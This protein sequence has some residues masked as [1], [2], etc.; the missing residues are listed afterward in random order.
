MR[1]ILFALALFA[2]PALGQGTQSTRDVN[3]A[4]IATATATTATNTTKTTAGTSATS[5]LPVQGVTGGVALPVS[6]SVS[7]GGTLPA[8][9]ATPTV[10]IG[11]LPSVAVTGTFWQT[12]QPVSGAASSFADGWNSTEGTKADSAWTTGSGSIDAVLKAIDRD[13]NAPL[14]GAVTTAA[15][16]YTSGTTNSVSLTIGGAMRDD[17]SSYNSTAL[18]GT[19]TAYGTAPTGNVFGVNAAVTNTV[20]ISAASLPLPSGAA[21]SAN[22]PT[23]AAQAGSITSA[24]GTLAMTSTTTATPT[25]T[26]ATMNP[27]ST[28]TQGGL[29]ID[30]SSIAGQAQNSTHGNGSTTNSLATYQVTAT[31]ST[32]QNATAFAGAG[33][34]IGT[35]VTG[36]T[37]SG[38]VI[39]GSI[40]V[41]ALTLGTASGVI[42]CAQELPDAVNDTDI[43]CSDPATATGYIRVPA[44]S[45]AGRRRWR[46]FSVGGT[47]TTV[48]A[49]ITVSELPSGGNYPLQHQ[50]RDAYAATN[51]FATRI[52]GVAQTASSLVLTTANSTSTVFYVEG[53]KA[54]TAFV[55]V[56]GGTPSTNPVLTLQISLDCVN[57][58]AS[59]VTLTPTAAGTFF[60]SLA[61]TPARCARFIVSTAS[62]GGS[63]YTLGNLGINAVN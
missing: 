23:N 7:I 6:G 41:T 56:T 61:N 34:V 59:G 51:P 22:Q 9:A 32:D 25:Y 29:R 13:I 8:F 24:T 14:P 12:T 28:T 11:T 19:V 5:A 27:L 58:G 35:M 15:P 37:G 26:T 38:A 57:Y 55:T 50:F 40:N 1:R 39:A 43:W 47:S 62:S 48:T 44:L 52:N 4:A 42:F 17:I 46:A 20:A 10:N 18:T 21:T 60:G 31:P 16:S 45:I 54:L 3:S 63:A 49:T 2:S 33:S 53:T 30:I 36:G